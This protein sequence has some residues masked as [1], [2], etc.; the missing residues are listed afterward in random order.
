MAYLTNQRRDGST[1]I[2]QFIASLEKETCI[3]CGRCYKACTQK[4]FNLQEDEDDDGNT[5]SY[6]IV[7]KSE[8]CI[9]CM[10]CKNVCSKKNIVLQAFEI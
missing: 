9:G 10:S 4:V 1:W 6:M 5:T 7:E 2:P 3:G 8:M